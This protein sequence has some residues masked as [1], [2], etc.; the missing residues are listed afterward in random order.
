[1]KIFRRNKS[2]TIDFTNVFIREFES[3]R[4]FFKVIILGKIKIKKR[5]KKNLLVRFEE[6]ETVLYGFTDD[7]TIETFI[8]RINKILKTQ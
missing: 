2:V 3:R 8:K 6:R 5:L 7:F 4:Y 1:M